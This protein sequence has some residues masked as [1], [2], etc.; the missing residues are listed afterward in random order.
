MI[1]CRNPSLGLTTKARGLQSYKPRGSSG[2][3]PHA[4]GSVGRCDGVNLY[5]LKATPIWEMES[6]W[7]LEFSEGNCMGQNSMNWGV[8]Y[9][10]KKLLECRCLKWACIA[11]LHIWNTSYDEKKGWESNWQFD[12]W[13]LKVRNQSDSLVCRWRATYRWK[14]L[15][16]G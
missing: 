7:T 14:D 5:T 16:E 11:H 15:D 1:I 6:Q 13:P 10:I 9:I 12:S 4:P 2:V 8:L 3:T